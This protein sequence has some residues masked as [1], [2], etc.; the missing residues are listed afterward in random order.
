MARRKT[1]LLEE[2]SQVWMD[3]EVRYP[4]GNRNPR[5]LGPLDG[6]W[7]RRMNGIYRREC[8]PNGFWLDR[9]RY[10]HRCSNLKTTLRLTTTEDS[11]LTGA[12]MAGRRIGAFVPFPRVNIRE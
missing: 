10:Q 7:M 8:G 1:A 9:Q 6:H 3:R 11:F 4:L 5:G 2:I 12:S